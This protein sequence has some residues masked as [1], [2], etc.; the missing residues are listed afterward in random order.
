M[1]RNCE[2]CAEGHRGDP[3]AG[4]ACEECDVCYDQYLELSR[5]VPSEVAALDQFVQSCQGWQDGFDFFDLFR[6]NLTELSRLISRVKLSNSST[7]CQLR[8]SLN[9]TRGF[10]YEISQILTSIQSLDAT[11]TIEKT[12]ILIYVAGGYLSNL[13]NLS[14]DN[15]IEEIYLNP[16]FYSYFAHFNQSMSL[17]NTSNS[18]FQIAR[19]LQVIL[20]KADASISRIIQLYLSIDLSEFP[21]QLATLERYRNVVS[22]VSIAART[23]LCGGDDTQCNDGTYQRLAVVA[24]EL[25]TLLTNLTERRSSLIEPLD[26]LTANKTIFENLLSRLSSLR[27]TILPINTSVCELVPLVHYAISRVNASI[28]Q[29]ADASE[30]E[31]VSSE[32]LQLTIS[33]TLT[34]T[35]EIVLF[36]NNTLQQ[37]LD[38]ELILKSGI[39]SLELP[40]PFLAALNTHYERLELL[41][42]QLLALSPDV[43][44]YTQSVAEQL[45]Q[46][47][48]LI[49]QITNLSVTVEQ[50]ISDVT[51]IDEVVPGLIE[52]V[53]NLTADVER[54]TALREE[55]QI[56][57]SAVNSRAS[58]LNRTIETLAVKTSTIIPEAEEIVTRTKNI[59]NTV[60]ERFRRLNESYPRVQTLRAMLAVHLVKLSELQT[61]ADSLTA[62]QDALEALLT[63]T[64]DHLDTHVLSGQLQEIDSTGK[65]L[66]YVRES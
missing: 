35:T 39:P 52:R 1:G 47:Q 62:R 41:Y 17:L 9:E 23:S 22:D 20:S 34:E 59:N 12:N 25:Q 60:M 61:F 31:R 42:T 38:N 66:N 45:T 50:I 24:I 29:T 57:L 65:C 63:R 30:L 44:T 58:E 15:F 18:F 55:N 36:I 48:L 2:N 7:V 11:D 27:D 3:V 10:L 6:A 4:V 43:T 33:L 32:I 51:A 37:V 13:K 64:E 14:L 26:S 5:A 46:L 49:E 16:R 19:R 54:V 21:E 40:A 56:R 53:T 8:D 28:E